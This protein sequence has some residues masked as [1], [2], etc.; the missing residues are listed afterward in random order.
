M[1]EASPFIADSSFFLFSRQWQEYK[2]SESPKNAF[3][4]DNKT[5]IR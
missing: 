2:K 4:K 1:P 5:E 3:G